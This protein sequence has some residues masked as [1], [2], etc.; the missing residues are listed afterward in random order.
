M[1][2][3][4][5]LLSSLIALVVA[6]PV[7][8]DKDKDKDKGRGH[9]HSR[10]IAM[11]PGSARIVVTDRDRTAVYTFYRTEFVAGRCPPGL[12]KKGNGCLPP[13]LAKRAW[14]IG[15][16]LARTIA[17]YPLPGPLL[18]QLTP[19]PEGYQYV[20]V[21]NDVVLMALGTRIV[22]ESVGSISDLAEP[23][24]PLVADRDREAVAAYYRDDYLAGN[25]PS[26]L[27]RT[28]Q[29][30][31]PKRVWALGEPL[32]PGVTYEELPQPLIAQLDPAPLGY[33]YG[34]IGEF[35]LLIS[36]ETRV[37]NALVLDLS[38]LPV[39]G[40]A[41]A[42]AAVI[43]PERVEYLGSGSCPPGL[44]KKN[45]GCLPPGHAR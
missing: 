14:S 28:N 37:V 18:A 44:A 9:G 6:L 8:A 25:C 30:C 2:I 24:R 38:R 17:F 4:P 43:V 40:V 29:G 3:A 36:P 13:G 1:R 33:A 41:S 45:N 35:I 22:T 23:I 27:V 32:D 11:A 19:A 34:R 20:R 12:A 21:D 26:G 7:H 42:P 39:A 10:S 5:L 15:A 16:P 31:Q